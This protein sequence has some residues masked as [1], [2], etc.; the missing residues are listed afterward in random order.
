MPRGRQA[1]VI[2]T[3]VPVTAN[4]REGGSYACAS[5]CALELLAIKDRGHLLLD[6]QGLILAEYRSYLN[7]SGQPGAGDAFLRW[8]FNNRW[9]AD[10][11]S[12]VPIQQ[13]EHEW[14]RFEEFPGNIELKDF[15]PS[16]QKFVAVA[17]ASELKAA[18]LQ[19]SDHKW[20]KWHDAL[21]ECEITVRFL[22]KEE[23]QAT[24]HRKS[25]PN[26]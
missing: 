9:K 18:I 3:N 4:R 26:S 2:D 15:D 13:I 1:T 19:A 6:D 23:L 11:C 7:Y 12:S 21:K 16:D 8:F 10:L 17:N 22:C 24:A 20:L 5:A 25:S 14:R